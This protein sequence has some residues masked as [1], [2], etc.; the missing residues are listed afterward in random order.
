[1]KLK[2]IVRELLFLGNHLNPRTYKQTHISTV[3][4]GGGGVH[5][6]PLGFRHVTI[7][8]KV[9]TFSR[10]PVMYSKR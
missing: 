8:C 10:K 4:Q 2:K 9:F 6:I 1:M 7:F 3:V 5:G